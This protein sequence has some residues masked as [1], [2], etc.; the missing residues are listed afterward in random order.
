[1]VSVG[2]RV[3]SRCALAGATARHKQAR[4]AAFL[5]LLGPNTTLGSRV[6][7]LT[8]SINTAK[9]VEELVDALN[10][11]IVQHS[12]G[13]GKLF[14]LLKGKHQKSSTHFVL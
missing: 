13:Y 12:T 2:V 4:I 8:F 11:P 5:A 3:T 1:M 10:V 7:L 6:R 9:T 14:E